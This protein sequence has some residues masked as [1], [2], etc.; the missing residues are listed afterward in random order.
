MNCHEHAEP[1]SAR[2]T[3]DVD[4]D[5]VIRSITGQFAI[6]F[7]KPELVAECCSQL[8]RALSVPPAPSDVVRLSGLVPVITE[9]A[10]PLVF[11]VYDLLERVAASCSNPWGCPA[12]RSTS[13]SAA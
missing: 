9:H 13:G 10:G 12:T 8:E 2:H 1:D 5:G 3:E 6:V 11:P 4:L 7:G